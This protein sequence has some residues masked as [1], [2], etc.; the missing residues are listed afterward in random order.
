MAADHV[1]NLS[2]AASTGVP[3]ESR[4]E[5]PFHKRKNSQT[6]LDLFRPRGDDDYPPVFVLCHP[7]TRQLAEKIVKKA[8]EEETATI[9]SPSGAKVHARQFRCIIR[10]SAWH[11]VQWNLSIVDSI[12]TQLAV[13][14]TGEPL[15][16][17]LH[18][19][20]AS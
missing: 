20:P 6:P 11:T 16:S 17:G 12:G 13:L 8:N 4:S 18:W 10:T 5:V 1:S 19:D 14:Y 15:Y 9:R 3:T 2:A 7:S